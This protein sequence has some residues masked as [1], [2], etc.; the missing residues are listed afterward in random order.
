[1]STLD[2]EGA[3]LWYDSQGTGTPLIVLHGGLGL[4][5]TYLRP[6]L[7]PLA[8]H[9]QLTYL[10]FRANGRSTGDG[11]DLTL[12]R[13]AHD[14]D[15]L[16]EHLGH[17]R[18]WLLGHSYGGFVALEYALTFPQ[19]LLGLMLLDTDSTAP[20]EETMAAGLQRLGVR[21]EEM[22][23]LGTPVQTDEDLLRLFDVAGPWYL[24]HSEPTRA[25]EVLGATRYREEGAAAGER[26][27]HD[28]DVTDRLSAIAVPSLVLSGADDFMFPPARA[29]RLGAALP[30]ATVE[31]VDGAGHLPF[32]ERADAVLPVLVEFVRRSGSVG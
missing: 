16:R 5:H 4:D 23:V 17:R 19:H 6:W 28:W 3:T 31:V 13:L 15:T 11:A 8:E 7:D 18:T 20:T 21:P 1:M 32:V 12:Q 22:A 25:R 2:C 14:V 24:P 27:L 9:L 26:A 30:S 29:A 10:D